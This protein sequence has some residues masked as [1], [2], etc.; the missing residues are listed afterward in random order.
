MGATITDLDIELKMK[1]SRIENLETKKTH[2]I[3]K[4]SGNHL[5]SRSCDVDS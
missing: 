1:I 2:K 3:L 5:Y 4:E